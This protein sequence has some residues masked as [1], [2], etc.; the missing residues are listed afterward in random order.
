MLIDPNS[1]FSSIITHYQK[2]KILNHFKNDR[3]SQFFTIINLLNIVRNIDDDYHQWKKK[4][5][6]NKFKKKITRFFF[7][8]NSHRLERRGR[9]RVKRRD[10]L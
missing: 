4:R 5:R 3:G 6:K 1:R 2:K 8:S 10:N 9:E 7:F